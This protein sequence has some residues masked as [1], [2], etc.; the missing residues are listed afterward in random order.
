M[1]DY[2]ARLAD[3]IAQ[4]HTVCRH[5]TPTPHGCR[6]CLLN[7]AFR[8]GDW[9][10]VFATA[11][12]QEAVPE[13]PLSSTEAEVLI[14]RVARRLK[15]AAA[16]V[17]RGV[18]APH[19]VPPDCASAVH[20]NRWGV[21]VQHICRS[22]STLADFYSLPRVEAVHGPRVSHG[23][24]HASALAGVFPLPLTALIGE[25]LANEHSCYCLIGLLY[26]YPIDNTLD[27]L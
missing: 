23:H 14:D 22:D 4:E 3:G 27:L 11:Q 24:C 10:H 26:G 2:L 17:L 5:A 8:G 25:D 19:A 9:T 6:E 7:Y 1:T 18:R 21:R 12:Q 20:T 15:P 13:W 16:L